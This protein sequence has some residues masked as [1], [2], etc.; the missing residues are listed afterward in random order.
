MEIADLEDYKCKYM[1]KV[2]KAVDETP[3]DGASPK[4][5]IMRC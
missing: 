3:E 5:C 2:V 1:I 4:R